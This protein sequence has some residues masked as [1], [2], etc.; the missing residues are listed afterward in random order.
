VMDDVVSDYRLPDDL[1]PPAF[2][3]VG[4]LRWLIV[5]EQLVST[6]GASTVLLGC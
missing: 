6:E 1:Q 5:G 2:P 3:L 4:R